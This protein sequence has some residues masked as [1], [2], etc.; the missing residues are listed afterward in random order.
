MTSCTL[1][2]YPALAWGCPAAAVAMAEAK[3]IREL[4]KTWGAVC[5]PSL[6]LCWSGRSWK[7]PGVAGCSAVCVAPEGTRCYASVL[8]TL[9]VLGTSLV[10]ILLCWS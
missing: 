4:I 10:S 3:V 9:R 7:D 1:E 8:L 2:C 6:I 5:C